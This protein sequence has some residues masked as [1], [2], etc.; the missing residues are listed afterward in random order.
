MN[1]IKI[2]LS[3]ILLFS[4][5]LLNA[6]QKSFSSEP[7]V[8]INELVKHMMD[9]GQEHVAKEAQKFKAAWDAGKFD[10]K[11]KMAIR[12]ICEDMLFRK[13]TVQPYFELFVSTINY[14]FANNID[15]KVLTQWQNISG[16]LLAKNAK[17]YLAFLQTANKLFAENILYSTDQLKWYADNNK[18]E[19]IYDGRV[20]IKF[21][22]LNL[23]GEAF[24]DKMQIYDTEGVFYPDKVTWVG[25]NGK[26]NWSRVGMAEEE[27]SCR[28]T[29][30][31]IDLAGSTYTADSAYL[32]YPKYFKG[33]VLGRV[34]DQVSFST[35]QDQLANGN[36]PKFS[37]YKGNVKIDGLVGDMATYSGGFSLIG[38]VITGD[39]VNSDPVTITLLQDKKPRVILQSQSFKIDEGVVLSLNSSFTVLLDSNK[40]IYHPAVEIRYDFNKKELIINKGDKGLMQMTFQDNFHGVDI[41]AERIVWKQ[42]TPYVEFRN[43]SPEKPVAIESNDFFKEFR[44]EKVQGILAYN[45]L[46]RM[47][48]YSLK[49]RQRKFHLDDYCAFYNSKKENIQEQIINLADDG[50]IF[51]D[52]KTDSIE[53]R[54]RLFNYVNNYMK[55][56][57]Y[58][59]VRMLSVI[60]ARPNVTLSLNNM[61][62][63]VEGVRKFTFSDSQNCI[64][65]PNEQQVLIKKDRNMTF[66]GIVRAGKVDFYSKA[67]N[68]DYNAFMIRDTYYDSM[69]LYYPDET[70]QALRKVQSVLSDLYGTI[71][72]DYPKNKS[73]LKKKDYPDYPIFTSEKG[74]KVHYEYEQTHNFS[75]KK[76]SFYFGVD[77]FRI[78]N[79]ND[80]TAANLK[81]PGTFISADIFPDFRYELTI[82]P[83]YSLGFV[84]DIDL[85]MYKSKGNGKMNIS[86]SNK[87]LYGNG[88]ITYQTSSTKSDD[89]LILPK[90]TQANSKTFD[91]PES[92]KYP[93]VSGVDVTTRWLPYEDKMLVTHN[94]TKFNVFQTH[95]KFGGTL[96]L[97]PTALAGN[98][99]LEWNEAEFYSKNMIYGKNKVDADTSGIRIFSIDPQVFAFQTSNVESHIDFDKRKGNFIANSPDNMTYLPA[100]QYGTILS[101]YT[102]KMD[103]K[104]ME[105]RPN[106][107]FPAVKPFFVSTKPDQD[108]LKFECSYADFD[109][110]E[111][112]VYMEKI[113][114]IDVADSRVYPFANKAIVRKDADI[115]RLDSSLIEANRVD[116]YH[117]IYNAHTKIYGKN[118]IRASGLYDFKTKLGEQHVINMDSIKI[119][120]QKHLVGVGNITDSQSFYLDVEIGYKGWAKIISTDKPI[121][122]TGF[123][124]PIHSMDYV[125]GQWL[126]FKGEMDALDVVIDVNN[127]RNVDNRPLLTGLFVA[128][129]SVRVYPMLFGMKQAYSNPEVTLDSGVL[130]YDHNTGD[131]VVGDKRKL[132][133]KEE[134]GNVIRVNDKNRTIKTA[135][136]YGMSLN[137]K[138]GIKSGFAGTSEWK[139]SDTTFNFDWSFYFDFPLPKEAVTRMVE[140]VK[141]ENYGSSVSVKT[142]TFAANLPEFYATSAASKS[143]VSRV[144]NSGNLNSENVVATSQFFK[145]VG[146]ATDKVK[147]IFDT[148][149]Y[150][151]EVNERAP[152]KAM[153]FV[154]ASNWYFNNRTNSFICNGSIDLAS[155]NG[156]N[157]NKRFGAI[158]VVDKKRSGDDIHI[159][160]ELN[161]NEFIYLNYVRGVMYAYSTDEK[162]NQIILDKG[163]KISNDDYSL[164]RGTPR[165]I[166]K[167]LRRFE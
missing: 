62:L 139:E 161:P 55:V 143:V 103:D 45:P 23:T 95:Y 134:K 97:S 81:L 142:S 146:K 79:L 26:I 162:F 135:G 109:M 53:V 11:E 153:F 15:K 159:Y 50:Y 157:I 94:E 48:D 102:W 100:N 38:K 116:K 12:D 56:R 131:I 113:P 130:Y 67:F 65:V 154:A 110:K 98:G 78:T 165:S 118:N 86:L 121:T 101:D 32:R 87:G 124:K 47:R 137:V 152:E 63:Q 66:G 76:E 64:A 150:I 30:Y 1:K 74:S 33:D 144:K 96:A 43:M 91:L 31:K 148:D 80:F 52:M 34:T 22:Y 17:E 163:E 73:G 37:S 46:Y 155:I 51:Y 122:Y 136:S 4:C 14:Y 115:D 72:F 40:T 60:S 99:Q 57:D 127:A 68:F 107:K 147:E 149:L 145:S 3:I 119:D 129:D 123:V 126:R 167:L 28:L 13:L 108:S 93:L 151:K 58:D 104:R 41:D 9:N 92:S 70:T 82:Q 158:I 88:E 20:A 138:S 89:F 128:G 71:E 19:L 54:D 42:N 117:K 156:V 120:E 39:N 7:E 29:T 36:Y 84:K 18:F 140:L 112:V 69:V 141:N 24:L 90:E 83:D 10:E 125:S 61:N 133:E 49:T 25:K 21:K 75:Y 6:Q 16:K 166:D 35:S 164:R 114:F 2:L 106:T 44:Y 85:P 77:P 5:T 27:A 160:I 132:F 59:V 105:M 8:F 111:N